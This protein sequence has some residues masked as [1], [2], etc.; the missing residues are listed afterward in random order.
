MT[1]KDNAPNCNKFLETIQLLIFFNMR[2][3]MIDK[4]NI[5]PTIPCSDKNSK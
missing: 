5:V 2:K 1:T 3:K 4:K